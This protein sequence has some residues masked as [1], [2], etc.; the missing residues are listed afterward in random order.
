MHQQQ[1]QQERQQQL[2]QQLSVGQS[3]SSVV[4]LA[5]LQQQLSAEL[6]G[7]VLDDKWLSY[8]CIRQKT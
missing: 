4:T 1:Q 5:K 6:P 8:R 7:A 2:L 3:Q